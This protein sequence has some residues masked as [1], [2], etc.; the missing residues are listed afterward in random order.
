MANYDD[1]NKS[2]PQISKELFRRWRDARQS[3]DLEARDAVDFVLGNHFTSEESNALSSIGQADFVIDRVYAAVDKLKS[4]LTA[5]PAKF[6]AIGREDSDNKLANVWKT[7]LE[8]IWDIS[9]GDTVFKQVV[10]DYAVQG[11][12]YMYVYMDPEADYGRGEIKYTHVD[13]FRVYVDPASRDRFFH[14]ASG[15]ILSTFLTRQQVLDLYPQL[16]EVID[17]IDVGENSLYGEDYPSSSMKNTQN[18]LTPAEA[19]NLDY[20][21]NQKY[22][23]LDRFYKVRVP[24]YRLFNSASGQEKIIDAQIYANIL[25][26]EENVEAIASGAIQ[27]EEVDQTRIMQCSSIG[28]VL[29]YERVLNTDIYPIVPF[30]NIWTNTP[31]PKSDVNKVKDSQRL[32]NKL[33]S[34]TLSHAQSAAGL[35]LLI[36]EGSIDNVSQLEKDWANPNAVIEYNPEF[37]EPHYPQPA[38]LTSEFYY[39]IDRVEKYIDLNFGIPELLQGFKDQAPESVRG[40]MLLSEMG[41][42]RGKSKLRDIE[43]SLTQVG[44]V[45]YNLSK[46]HYKFQK[47]FRVVQPNN[48]ITEFTVNMRL[49]DDKTNEVASLEND[50]SIGQHDIRIISGSTLPSNKVAEYNMYLDAYKLGL[51]DD[52]EVLKKSE[53]FDKEGVLQRKGQMAQMQQYIAQLESQVKKLSGDLQTSEREQLSARKRTEVEKFKTNLNEVVS[54]AKVKRQEKQMQ[55]NNLV[56][57]LASSAEDEE[58]NNPGSER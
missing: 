28:D 34:L 48:D 36:P 50:L 3:W 10:H 9:K 14:D 51:V 2:K 43:A 45:I 8:Y 11:L 29:L 58:N 26:E 1:T 38:P 35:K 42:S 55:L 24:Y 22:Q 16:E 40:T 30:A 18:V 32:L 19:K 20:N 31:Y 49:Y 33:F 13:P 37:G 17:D 56:D 41:E 21:V 7:I 54:S 52:V 57:Q 47:T 23:V 53:I 44:Q 5:Q 39:L 25:Q 12:G 15:I 6:S 46:E 4:L 27:I